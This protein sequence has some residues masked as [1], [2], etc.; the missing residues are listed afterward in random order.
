MLQRGRLYWARLD[1]RRPVLVL[2]PDYRNARASD[3]IVVPCSTRLRAAPTHVRLRRREGGAPQAFILKCEQITT[4]P[5][6]EIDPCALGS[7][8]SAARMADV[9]RSVLRAIGVAVGY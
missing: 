3:V 4:L 1:K 7:P 5:A 6:D 9:E 8:L 2:S